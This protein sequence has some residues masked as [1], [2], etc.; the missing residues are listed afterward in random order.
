MGWA[1]KVLIVGLIGFAVAACVSW[2]APFAPRV[3]DEFSYLLAADTLLHGRLSNP[4]PEVWQPFQSFHILVSPAYVSKYPLGQG[5]FVAL[6][7]LLL[8]LPIAG[9]WL[10]AGLC[11]SST[12]WMLAGLVSRRWAVAGGLLV[13]CHPAMQSMWSQSLLSGWITAAGSTLLTGSVLRLRRRFGTTAALA[14]GSGIALL[15][16]TR[17]YEGLV[18]TCLLSLLLWAL[19]KGRDFRFRWLSAVRIVPV[20]GIPVAVA[21]TLI[22]LQNVAVSGKLSGLPYRLHEEQYSAAPLFVFGQVS[23]P[24]LEATGE[25]PQTVIDFQHGWALDSFRERPGFTGWLIGIARA[26]N[27]LWGF[28]VLLAMAPVLS[29]GWW[30]RFRLPRL[31][32]VIAAVQ[33]MFSAAVCWVFPHYLS[34]LLPWLVAL[35]ILGLK[36][37]FRIF[38][39]AQ[40]VGLNH[41]HRFAAAIVGAQLVLLA[42]SAF[43]VHRD[44]DRVWAVQRAQI[45]ATL[46]SQG[47]EHLVLVHYSPQHNVHREWVYNLSDLERSPVLWARGERQDWNRQLMTRYSHQRH[48]WRIDADA[49]NPQPQLVSSPTTVATAFVP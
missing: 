12:T 10:A 17:P 6:G 16:L 14:G 8:G 22:A 40:V 23:S 45:V 41:S 4:T 47:G 25:V 20:A 36:R 9:C 1:S 3:H 32:L 34:P 30:S 5:M 31:L 24:Q 28:W 26:L 49:T 11:A 15:A 43:R 48:I 38:V 44:P 33:I 35:S 19:W 27:T 21:L 7:W 29:I 2:I 42:I 13:A 37:I 18:A 46:E 39:R